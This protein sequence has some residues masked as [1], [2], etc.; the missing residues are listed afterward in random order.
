[1]ADQFKSKRVSF[2][3]DDLFKNGEIFVENGKEESEN[4]VEK[5][6]EKIMKDPVIDHKTAPIRRKQPRR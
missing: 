5:H 4:A 3:M 2:R 6:N 1:M